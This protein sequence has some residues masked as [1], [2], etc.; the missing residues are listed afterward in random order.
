MARAI[1]SAP[2]EAPPLIRLCSRTGARERCDADG[3]VFP[4]CWYEDAGLLL[5]EGAA[6]AWNWRRPNASE[7]EL[8][9][10]LPRLRIHTRRQGFGCI[11]RKS[12]WSARGLL[13]V[14]AMGA[15]VGGDVGVVWVWAVVGM[16]M[17]MGPCVGLL[18]VVR[19]LWRWCNGDGDGGGGVGGG[20]GEGGKEA[21]LVGDGV[22]MV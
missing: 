3:K 18:A 19:V 2:E 20:G 14:V 5:Q 17:R 15:G 1:R 7:V 22:L 12:C 13:Q 6:G 4:H 21:G 16:W 8:H 11:T 10:G 9:M